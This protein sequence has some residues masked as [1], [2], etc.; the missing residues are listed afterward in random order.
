MDELVR[1]AELLGV[2]LTDDQVKGFERY[3]RLLI[4]WNKHMNLTTVTDHEEVQLRHFLDS[5]TVLSVL[6][7]QETKTVELHIVDIG[8]GAGFPGLPLKIVLPEA[9]VVLLEAARKKAEFLRAVV[10]T[11]GLGGVEVV[12]QRA[13]SAAHSP[14]YRERFELAVS[15]AVASLPTLVELALPFC[16]IGGLFVAQKKGD[17]AEEVARGER[18]A[19][20]LGGTLTGVQSVSIGLQEDDRK[21]VMWHKEW[22]TSEKYPRRPGVPERRPL[23]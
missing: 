17:I 2:H 7:G 4:Q 20:T 10:Q 14:L 15:R 1:G 13:E 18:A 22:T 5:L 19:G 9:Q 8:S 12:N 6:R 3:Y 16:R 11:L 21:L 23:A